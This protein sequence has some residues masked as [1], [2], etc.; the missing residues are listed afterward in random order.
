G[1]CQREAEVEID[2][3]RR[4]IDVN[5]DL[6]L[7][8]VATG[9]IA[10]A[11]PKS[12]RDES[13]WCRGQNPPRTVEQALRGMIMDIAAEV[14]RDIA[15]RTEDYTVRFRES[16]KDLPKELVKPFR[17]IVKQTQRDLPGACAAWAA[18]DVQAPN[19]PS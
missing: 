18:M 16:N 14:R 4:V 17:E 15:P 7:T 19:H 10:Y 11:A 12:R 13:S 8:A 1:K 9:A 5:A 3:T 6:R 2:C